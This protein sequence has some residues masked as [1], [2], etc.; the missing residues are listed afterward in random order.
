[1]QFGLAKHGVGVGVGLGWDGE[2]DDAGE[3]CEGKN[4]HGAK[5]EGKVVST[6]VAIMVGMVGYNGNIWWR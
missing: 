1:M 6:V 5:D 3:K 4:E 2:E